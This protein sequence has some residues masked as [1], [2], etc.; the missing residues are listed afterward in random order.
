MMKAMIT[1]QA[2]QEDESPH[3][4]FNMVI[5]IEKKDRIDFHHQ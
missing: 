3:R 5:S 4:Y 1:R 2:E